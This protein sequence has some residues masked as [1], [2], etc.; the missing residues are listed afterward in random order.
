MEFTSIADAL[1]VRTSTATRW[2]TP[3]INPTQ[4]RVR[5]PYESDAS[6]SFESLGL[7]MEPTGIFRVAFEEAARVFGADYTLFSVNGTTWS[8]YVVIKALAKQ[9]P[10]LR[11]LSSRNVHRSVVSACEDYGARLMFLPTKM[12][13]RFHTFLPN[14]TAEILAGIARSKPQVLL[15]TTPTYEG[16][17]T[18]LCD[19]ICQAREVDPRLV[20]FVDEAWGAH[21]HFS[22]RLPR[23]AMASGA[24]ICVQSTHKQGGSLQQT[25]MI[26]WQGRRIDADL[27]GDAYRTL[28]TS[29]PSYLLLASLEAATAELAAHGFAQLDQMIDLAAQLS[30]AVASVPGFEV[31][32]IHRT[33]P[34]VELDRDLTKVLI[35]VSGSGLSGYAVARHL[36]TD[37]GIVVEAYNVSTILFLVPFGATLAD[38]KATRIALETIAGEGRHR[39][40]Y[41]LDL[42]D[43][44]PRVLDLTDVA[45]L[46]PEQLEDVPLLDAT[47]RICTEHITPFPP[48]IPTTIKGEELTAGLVAYYD[49]LRSI[50]NVHIAARS[51]SLQTVCVVR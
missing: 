4:L 36:E 6:I 15:L 28:G 46:L 17:A 43:S 22:P 42:P 19:L 31:A 13:K 8:N 34:G 12:S 27:L 24:D 44:V 7:P 10:N 32:E 5:E 38:V 16:L 45:R 33:A 20:I 30:G 9:H 39:L 2:C 23:S 25:G 11:I 48:G 14:T 35:D 51:P 21:L 47:G 40:E 50:P 26:H 37:H 49:R 18:D 1:N 29:S 3:S 41:R